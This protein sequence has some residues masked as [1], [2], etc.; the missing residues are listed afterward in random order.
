VRTLTPKQNDSVRHWT[1]V[2][3]RKHDNNQTVL[4]PKL[5]MSQGSLSAFLAGHR[6]T[7]YGVVECLAALLGKSEREIL[8]RGAQPFSV[9]ANRELAA[10]YAR[11]I[12]VSAEAIEEVLAEPITPE[13]EGWF[14]L[15]WAD[16]MREKDAERRRRLPSAAGSSKAPAGT[17]PK[18]PTGRR[19]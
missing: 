6:G 14:M 16:A 10:M 5:K 18:A 2:A 12:G 4:A 9:D 7:S 11:Q 13:R 8:G 17:S 1:R 15:W 19:R 3:L